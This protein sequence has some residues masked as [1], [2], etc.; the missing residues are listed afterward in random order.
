MVQNLVTICAAFLIAFIAGSWRMSLLMIGVLPV[1]AIGSMLQM[2]VAHGNN[3]NAQK[4]VAQAGKLAVQ[5]RGVKSSPLRRTR[6]V[7]RATPFTEP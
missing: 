6:F 7:S 1:V 5:V 3:D 2:K 4:S